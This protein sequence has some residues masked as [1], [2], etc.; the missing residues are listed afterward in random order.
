[1][2]DIIGR[3]YIPGFAMVKTDNSR[4]PLPKEKRVKTAIVHMNDRN[5]ITYI[6]QTFRKL[7]SKYLAGCFRPPFSNPKAFH[8]PLK[9]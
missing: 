1:M 9:Q 2:T 3:S 7:P 8:V 6:I 5:E 4:W